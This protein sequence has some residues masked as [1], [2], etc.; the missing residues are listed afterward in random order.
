MGQ[1][2]H[3]WILHWQDALLAITREQVRSNVSLRLQN[4]QPALKRLRG[5]S[6]VDTQTQVLFFAPVTS[7]M[8]TRIQR[9]WKLALGPFKDW[10]AGSAASQ[11]LLRNV[12]LRH[13]S[14]SRCGTM[15]ACVSA[16]QLD[17]AQLPVGSHQQVGVVHFLLQAPGNTARVASSQGSHLQLL[18]IHLHERALHAL[19]Q[20]R[21]ELLDARPLRSPGVAPARNPA[22]AR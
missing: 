12:Q 5:M 1:N 9:S 22:D 17:E 16:L 2:L 7:A 20:V 14:C 10:L 13:L 19:K 8:P 21:V 3:C 11:G 4:C 6:P 15:K 18:R